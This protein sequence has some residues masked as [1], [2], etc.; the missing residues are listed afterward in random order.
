MSSQ[1]VPTPPTS[2]NGPRIC[3][4]ADALAVIG[5]RWSLLVIRE[6][7]Y[8]VHRFNDIRA[9][10]GA[11]REMLAARLRT[12]EHAGVI[13]R[14]RYCAHPPRDEYVLTDAGRALQPVLRLLREWGEQ[15]T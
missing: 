10:T 6:I 5:E 12:L 9:N 8:G 3:K 14:Q 7:T 15:Y 2:L 11:P 13:A 1:S 4:I